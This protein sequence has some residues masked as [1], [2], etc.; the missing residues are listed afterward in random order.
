[1]SNYLLEQF[2]LSGPKKSYKSEYTNPEI[3]SSKIT[4]NHNNNIIEISDFQNNVISFYV[5]F[6]TIHNQL[7]FSEIASI[8]MRDYIERLKYNEYEILIPYNLNDFLQRVKLVGNILRI[9]CNN[10]NIKFTDIDNNITNYNNAILE[11][12]INDKVKKKLEKYLI[13]V[14][15]L[16]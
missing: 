1:M 13:K 4:I 2:N 3:I 7:F 12:T 9:D 11:F 14:A 6:G 16:V 15:S 10:L 5:L 8:C